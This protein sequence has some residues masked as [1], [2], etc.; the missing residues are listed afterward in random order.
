MIIKGKSGFVITTIGAVV[1]GIIFLVMGFST[2]SGLKNAAQAEDTK[3]ADY[4]EGM[5]LKGKTDLVWDYYCNEYEEKDGVK[6]ERFR[7]YLVYVKAPDVISEDC[8]IGVKV[9][10]SDFSKYEA[11]IEES[12]N[13]ELTYQGK[14]VKCTDD[15]LKYKNKFMEEADKIY[16]DELGIHVSTF[17][18]TPDY[19]VDLTTTKSGNTLMI[20]GGVCLGI[21]VILLLATIHQFR[22]SRDNSYED[23][24]N[25]V[26]Y[27]AL[28]SMYGASTGYGTASAGQNYNDNVDP[29]ADNLQNSNVGASTGFYLQGEQDELSKMLAEEDQKVAN[30]NF[31]TGLTG[32]NRVEDDK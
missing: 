8:Y 23:P 15:V 31:E 21:G 29:D 28:N 22:S 4:K 7:W 13:L 27:A 6:T 12:S 24:T 10:A 17:I 25:G 1:I 9:P 5:W 11:L 20:I 14:L 2:V 19:Y 30:Y 26:R 32:S 3:V 18:K 16:M